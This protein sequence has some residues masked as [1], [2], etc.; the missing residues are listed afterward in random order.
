MTTYDEKAIGV[1]GGLFSVV[2]MIQDTPS[3]RKY[4]CRA[5]ES[6]F[7]VGGDSCFDAETDLPSRTVVLLRGPSPNSSLPVRYRI[8][9]GL[10]PMANATKGRLD[11]RLS[12]FSNAFAS[13]CLLS[14]LPTTVSLSKSSC[15]ASF[16]DFRPLNLPCVLGVLHLELIS[17]CISRDSFVH[18]PT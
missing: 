8:C 12:I 3:R 10:H 11:L 18:F 17:S 6:T 16:Q 15:T 4:D 14:N 5:V 1:R 13:D 7:K 2:C 9:I